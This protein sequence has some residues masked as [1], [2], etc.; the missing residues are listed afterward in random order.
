MSSIDL[1]QYLIKQ[2]GSIAGARS[3]AG[4]IMVDSNERA[5]AECKI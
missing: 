3:A 4:P 1:K 5:F 2:S